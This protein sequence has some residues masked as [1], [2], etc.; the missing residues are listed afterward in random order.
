MY[1][2][3]FNYVY[4]CYL[5]VIDNL[6]SFVKLIV[7]ALLLVIKIVSFVTYKHVIYIKIH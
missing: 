5:F 7:F 2:L 6:V 4:V 1:H 3:R